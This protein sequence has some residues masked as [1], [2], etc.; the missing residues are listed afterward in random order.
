MNLNLM[1]NVTKLGGRS[2]WIH[3]TGPIG[4]LPY[5]LTNFP[6]AERDSA[7]CAKDFNEVVQ[8]FN[9]KYSI[10]LCLR[11]VSFKKCIVNLLLI[12]AINLCYFN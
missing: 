7:G 6:S 8:Y 5:I 9:F 12:Y 2:F 11:Y 3:N 10:S 4:C 1:Q